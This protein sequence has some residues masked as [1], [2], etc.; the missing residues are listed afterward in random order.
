MTT[1]L[2]SVCILRLKMLLK[3]LQSY[4]GSSLLPSTRLLLLFLSS[5]L[6]A[7]S[8]TNF[9]LYPS[10]CVIPNT[11][12]FHRTS[13][14]VII[15]ARISSTL[16]ANIYI[17][18]HQHI[19]ILMQSPALFILIT[20]CSGK[21]ERKQ[22]ASLTPFLTSFSYPHPFS[23]FLS[24]FVSIFFSIFHSIYLSHSFSLHITRSL[25]PFPFLSVFF[26]LALS[27]TFYIS[28][29]HI[30]CLA[31]SHSPSVFPRLYHLSVGEN[32]TSNLYGLYRGI[33]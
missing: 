21:C 30:F 28:L 29:S 7:S 32:C 19:Y 9:F 2:L 14:C 26:C 3:K 5:L 11:H 22:C 17:A 10:V 8:T 20:Y 4:I 13:L 27:L 16:L 25:S 23:P 12:S 33:A 31:L 18:F 1:D 24:F 6:S 15:V